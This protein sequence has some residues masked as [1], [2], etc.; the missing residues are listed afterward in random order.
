MKKRN[1]YNYGKSSERRLSGVSDYLQ[2]TARRAL[3]CS[4]VDF[5]VPWM[6]GVREDE[7]QNQI[8]KE[9]HS[10]CDGYKKKSLHQKKIDGKGQALDLVPYV[11]GI[12]FSYDAAGRFGIIGM[13]MLEAWEELQ[14]EGLIPKDLYLHW[15]GLWSH[16]DPVSLG[17]DLAHYEIRTYPQK[18]LV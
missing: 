5:G 15:G 4:P 12:G 17:W 1:K 7:E 6:G 18:E 2:M 3:I 16:K 8:F 14:E 10:R 9:G 11:A 13:L